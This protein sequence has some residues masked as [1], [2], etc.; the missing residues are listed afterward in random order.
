MLTNITQLKRLTDIL[1]CEG[2]ILILYKQEDE[3]YLSSYLTDNSGNV[4]YRT[5]ADN[6]LNY[7]KGSIT[8][9]EL[10][11]LSDDVLVTRKQREESA[12]YIK[13]D[14][15]HLLQCGNDYY[16]QISEGLKGKD[17]LQYLM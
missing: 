12:T 4:F 6:I 17:V 14:L 5:T 8:L 1:N 13:D 11:L 15:A 2:G 10:Y 7:L 9:R 3:L 16:T